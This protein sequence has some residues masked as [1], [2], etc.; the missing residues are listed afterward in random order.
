MTETFKGNC[1]GVRLAPRE[2][3][4]DHIEVTIIVEDDGEWHDAH[5]FSSHWL[6]EMISQLQ[7]ARAYAV[8]QEPD[9]A[10]PERGFDPPRQFGW[11][12]RKTPRTP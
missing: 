1:M 12:F 6:D 11:K 7:A 5:S 8:T 4:G 10:G 2:R 3:G 9:M